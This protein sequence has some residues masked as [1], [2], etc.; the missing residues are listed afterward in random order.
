MTGFIGREQEL[1][2]LEGLWGMRYQMALL[3]GR[4]RVG[5]TRLISEFADGKPT[6]SYQADEGTATEQLARFTER[7]IAYR[8]DP[9]LTAQPL[10]NWPAAIATI[11][12]LAREAK[13]QAHPLLL[14]LDEFPR[15]VV[16]TP[17][18]P[19]I[20]QAAIEDIKRDDLPLF[21][22]LAGSQIGMFEKH[23]VH[24]PLYGRRTWGERLPPL[25]YRE[26]AGFFPGWTHADR[27]RAWALLGG[28][29]YYLEQWDPSRTLDWNIRRRLLR[30]GAVLYDEADL[31]MKEELS[32][33]ASTYLSIIAAI[34]DGRNRPSEIGDR[35][36]LQ[37]TTVGKY[38]DQLA[39]LHMLRHPS[40]AGAAITSRKGIWQID[41]HYLRA[42]FRF[43]R[44][45]RTDLENRREDDVF[46]DR[47]KPVLD[48]FVSKPAFEDAA[49]EHV[50]GAIGRDPAF[51]RTG[52]VGAW[53][54]PVPDETHPG[55]RRTREGEIEIVAYD[56]HR[57]T[58]AAEAKWSKGREGGAALEQ[59]RG[60]VAHVPGYDPAQTRLAIYTRDGFTN[61]FRVR[62]AGEGVLLRTVDDLY[63]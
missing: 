16:S 58:L 10:A 61:A 62:A 59:L 2:D 31:M 39:R 57:L 48:H 13:A 28:I 42:W 9:V 7:I 29:P 21:L 5:K 49:R 36:G 35:A 38:L 40:P 46:R 24:G 60:T 53:W 34:A 63:A 30:K 47:I 26:A 6:I 8:P 4:R 43:I 56:G 41:D 23:V 55:T 50:S 3:Y 37:T 22:V 44:T 25:S 32:S 14:V 12:R 19:S 1:A 45:N 52:V 54:G 27:L 18:L 15:L 17:A 33:E 51:P 20:L 11:M